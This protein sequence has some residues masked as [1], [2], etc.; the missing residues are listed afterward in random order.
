MDRA[1]DEKRGGLDVV[2]AAQL[3][4]VRV[5]DDQ[6]RGCDFRPV[7][8]LCIDEEAIAATA[9]RDAEMVADTFTETEPRSPAQRC[10]EIDARE[11]FEFLVGHESLLSA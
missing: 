9:K 8:P 2:Q 6:I 7:Q 11:L 5:D 3:A 1:V 10:G 4:P